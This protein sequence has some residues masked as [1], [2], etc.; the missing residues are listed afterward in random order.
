MDA[1]CVA[2]PV[3]NTP[4]MGRRWCFLAFES[5]EGNIGCIKHDLSTPQAHEYG[6]NLIKESRFDIVRFFTNGDEA[7]T[8]LLNHIAEE[9]LHHHILNGASN[10]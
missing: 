2:F 5:I 9:T 6:V 1:E 4:L 8:F 3:T 10:E 7:L